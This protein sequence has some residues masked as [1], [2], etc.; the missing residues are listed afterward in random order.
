M[1]IY[2]H[3]LLLVQD[4]ID[5]KELIQYAGKLAKGNVAQI[6]LGHICDDYRELDYAIDS[7]TKDIQSEEVIK[8]KVMLSQLV[9]SS[10]IDID[11]KTIV[12]MNR[13]K[14]INT[15]IKK[16]GIDLLVL[17]HRNRLFGELS[18]FSFEFINHLE[19]DVVI[20]HILTPEK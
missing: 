11:V 14:D 20:K 13:F 10:E 18:S 15:L 3:A 9:K 7:P 5:G 6:S 16:E 17:G 8:A 2:N 12:S 4:E 19:V 1:L